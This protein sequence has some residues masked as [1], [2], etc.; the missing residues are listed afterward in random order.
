M[1]DREAVNSISLYTWWNEKICDY[2]EQKSNLLDYFYFDKDRCCAVIKNKWGIYNDLDEVIYDGE[3]GEYLCHY[4]LGYGERLAASVKIKREDFRQ[5]IGIVYK[6]LSHMIPNDKML[7]K[8]NEMKSIV[9]DNTVT[10]EY[11]NEK[12][13][14]LLKDAYIYGIYKGNSL[15]YIGKT[16]RPIM[17]RIKEHIDGI[18]DGV[19]GFYSKIG[20]M[21]NVHFK[22]LF[23]SHDGIIERELE[24][25]EKTFI[26]FFRPIFNIGGVK[27]EYKFEEKPRNNNEVFLDERLE[28]L[29]LELLL[30]KEYEDRILK[31]I[32]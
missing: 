1:I 19:E 7:E 20:G 9:E 18:N 21:N 2:I 16:H 13:K 15:V 27:T 10:F 17:L 23:E 24:Y 25:I 22:I 5:F 29:R 4:I 6:I 28:S 32:E 12:E 26:E 8:M 3:K 14:F 11:E 30:T 31:I